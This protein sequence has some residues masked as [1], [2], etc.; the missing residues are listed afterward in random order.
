MAKTAR[1]TSF[2]LALI[3]LLSSFGLIYLAVRQTRDREKLDSALNDDTNKVNADDTKNA[4]NNSSEG[5]MLENFQPTAD[6]VAELKIEDIKIGEGDEAKADS[7]ITA[8]Y[9]GAIVAT[10]KIFQSSKDTGQPFTSPLSNLISGWKTGIP[11]MK[12]GG[13]RRLTIPSDQAYGPNGSG[14]IP[15]N[16][17]LVFDIELIGVK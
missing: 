14:T 16:S 7:T 8:H 2:L 3:M 1:V 6:K 9:T 11:G 10:G 13:I 17:D 15:P 12:V 4:K 5:K